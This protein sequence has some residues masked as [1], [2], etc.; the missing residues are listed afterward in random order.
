MIDLHV[1][2]TMSDGTYTPSQLIKLAKDKG[3]KAIAL[4]DHDTIYGNKEAY[5]AAKK[6]DMEFIHGME[7]SL[8][9]NNHQ[10]HVV[11]LGFDEES[12][13]FKD[14]YHELR[15]KKQSSI[16]SVID[17]LQKQGL[18]IS[19]EKVKPFIAGGALDKYAILRYLVS[20]KSKAGDIQYLWDRYIDPAFNNLNLKIIENPKAEDAIQAMKKAGAVTSLAHFH[21][22]I[23]FKNYTREEQEAN[24]KYLHE[25]G[26]DGMEAYYPN[27]S[28]DDEKFAHYLIEKYGL[29][30]TG[31]TDFHGANR[32][33]VDLGSGTNN[34]LD[35]PYEFYQ[36]ICKLIKR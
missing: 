33:S 27:Y 26:L 16:V 14:F 30:P 3:L 8:N 28:E 4:T 2:S 9:Y 29:V 6:Y 24:I 17:Y 34:N 7:L 36:N 31:G 11:A 18:D 21:K 15:Q 23:G 35:V 10:I 22:K 12:K 13:A 20:D 5:E 32:P 25:I 19:V 1:H